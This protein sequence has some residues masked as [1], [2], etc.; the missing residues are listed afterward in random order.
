MAERHLDR[1]REHTT[2]I[3]HD[4]QTIAHALT[5][6]QPHDD[7]ERPPK[8]LVP[9]GT[10]TNTATEA[11]LTA[12]EAAQHR[13]ARHYAQL[14]TGDDD[15]HLR[16]GITGAHRQLAD[17]AHPPTLTVHTGRDTELT[18][19][20]AATTAGHPEHAATP[21]SPEWRA[22]V[23]ALADLWHAAAQ[24][25]IDAHRALADRALVYDHRRNMQ[26]EDDTITVAITDHTRQLADLARAVTKLRDRVA[27][28]TPRMCADGC[29]R[30]A[31]PRGE[32]ATCQACR[33][34]RRTTSR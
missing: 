4:T 13:D 14:L 16:R 33:N 1:I 34:E 5:T 28:P 26:V 3:T 27:P 15:L 21:D 23:N 12:W 30:P 9:R 19:D 31:P 6:R 10:T 17:L 29:G 8:P 18:V 25:L 2:R 24:D 22:A 32:G 7:Y 11:H 20:Q